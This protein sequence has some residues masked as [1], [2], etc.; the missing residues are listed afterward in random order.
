MDE[1]IR[2]RDALARNEEIPE[3]FVAIE[4]R[5]CDSLRKLTKRCLEL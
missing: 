2:K 4:A 1:I 5:V 3:A